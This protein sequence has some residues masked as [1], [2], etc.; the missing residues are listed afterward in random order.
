MATPER[1]A[2]IARTWQQVCFHL[3]GLAIGTSVETINDL[4][5]FSQLSNSADPVD[6]SDIAEALS[7]QPG[8]LNLVF[9]LLEL[10]GYV[11]RTGDIANGRAFVTL[12]PAGREWLIY[13]GAYTGF[14]DRVLAAQT[15]MAGQDSEL[16]DV[17][18]QLPDRIRCH[19][20]GPMA[21][22][23]LTALSRS[24]LFANPVDVIAVNKLPHP[25]MAEELV[26]LGW[27]SLQN[28]AVQLNEAGR[29]A[30]SFAA[31]YYYPVSYLPTLA[32]VPDMLTGVGSAIAGRED[33]G[34]EGH[35]D[36]ELDIAFSGIVFA[37]TCRDPLFDLVLRLFDETD[38]NGQ[39]RAIVDCGGG[40]GTLLCELYQAIAER[41]SRGAM[42]DAHPLTMIG[43]EYN[44][45]AERTLRAR[46]QASDVPG[47]V[48][49]GDV[50]DPAAI[51][52]RLALEG[53][54]RD[55]VLHVSK[56]VF[57][58]RTYA[59]TLA[60][61]AGTSLGAF[62]VPG[63]GLLTAG[64]VEADL[65]ALFALW[66]AEM[67]RHG[68]IVIEAH[69]IEAALATER[70]GRNVMTSLEA[71]HGYSHQYLVEIDAHRGAARRAGLKVIGS[72]DFG[73]PFLGAPIMSIDHYAV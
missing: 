28:D 10:Q 12:T 71:S 68:M 30:L 53:F 60:T 6:V 56:S 43:V 49:A 58:N 47:L 32:A 22:A 34:T 66:R 20:G 65:E 57:H 4:G 18:S 37:R 69:I 45:V 61:N 15:V 23:T 33:D 29:L 35:V 59:R 9:R 11:V 7:V 8:Y 13:V 44:P 63:G 21:A 51:T 67:G 55:D 54:A 39:P 64:E 24:E 3:D 1:Q 14:R 72:H 27:A 62:S 50:G 70:L 26:D 36:R 38:L 5:G 17:S 52:A 31:Q 25:L 2:L 48:F 40:D 16:F 46:M 41:T 42:L 19:L 73:A